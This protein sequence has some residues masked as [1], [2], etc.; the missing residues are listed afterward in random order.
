VVISETPVEAA[1]GLV[2]CSS[3]DRLQARPVQR[4]GGAPKDSVMMANSPAPDAEGVLPADDGNSN[5]DSFLQVVLL[6]AVSL[7]GR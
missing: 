7:S 2:D 6:G 3:D 1:T 4:S 5:R